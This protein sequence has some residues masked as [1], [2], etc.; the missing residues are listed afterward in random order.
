MAK[1]PAKPAAKKPAAKAAPKKAAKTAVATSV[2]AAPVPTATTTPA[3]VGMA[4]DKFASRV[5]DVSDGYK[6]SKAFTMLQKEKFRLYAEVNTD[7]VCGVVRSQ[8]SAKR[9]YA[10]RLAKDG[11]YSC[12]T[13]N[14]FQCV[15]SRGSPCKHL[16]VLVV[17]LVKAGQ[18]DGTMALEWLKL[19][20]KM[21][22]TADGYKPD[23]DVVTATFLKYKSMEAGEIDW[24][25]TDTI[26]EDFYSA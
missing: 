4:W 26:P 19:A 8:G 20:N 18:I 17:G 24:R 13:Q 10:C 5:Q 7:H 11:K 3:P 6:L 1:T 2:S 22:K 15:V 14:L 25:P 16:L 12:C 9:V 23:K 21:G